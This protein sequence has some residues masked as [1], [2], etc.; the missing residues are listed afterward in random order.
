MLVRTK[1]P[2]GYTTICGKRVY[3]EAFSYG[4][5]AP[6]EITYDIYRKNKNILKEV[7]ITPQWLSERF[8]GSFPNTLLTYENT[9]ENITFDDLIQI[10]QNLGIEYIK[11]AK[12]SKSEKRA[13]RRSV[14]SIIDSSG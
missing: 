8:G 11:S 13:L 2:M 5:F 12:P 9:F 10:A 4:R 6:T 7:P 14:I 3:G 1:E